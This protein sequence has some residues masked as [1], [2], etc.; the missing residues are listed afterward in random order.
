MT[1]RQIRAVLY[2]KRD[3]NGILTAPVLLPSSQRGKLPKA[4]KYPESLEEE[5]RQILPLREVVTN[6][7]EMVR[8]IHERWKTGQRN[9]GHS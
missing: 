5:L 4:V 6:Y 3:K 9:G 8:V 7:E 2:H 1:E